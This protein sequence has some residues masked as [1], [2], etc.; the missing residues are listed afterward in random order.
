M[1]LRTV[2]RD[3]ERALV[4]ILAATRT[5]AGLGEDISLIRCFDV[6]MW[7]V[8]RRDGLLHPRGRY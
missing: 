4:E 5:D 3:D 7:K 6:V 1:T 8:G 2:L